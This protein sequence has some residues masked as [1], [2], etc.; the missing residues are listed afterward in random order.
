VE[1]QLR[2]AAGE[3]LPQ[4]QDQ[5]HITG[6]AIEARVYAEDPA[7][8][9][10]P[11]IGTLVHL[12][13]PVETADV[14]VDTGV[15]QGDAITPNYDPMIAKL[16]V[17]GKDR[18]AAVQRLAMTLAQYEV[19]GVQTNLGL[20]RAIAAHPAFAGEELDTGFIARHAEVL[21]ADAEPPD[22]ARSEATA[23]TILAAAALAAFADRRAAHA[24][25]AA[26]S[27]DPWSPWN[28]A[29]AW[30]MNG[31][32]YQ[33][34]VL[35]QG[36]ES[37][38]LRAHPAEDGTY[39][40]DLPCG[41]VHAE[42]AEDPEAGMTL[43]LDGV[44]HRLRVVRRD[45]ELVVILHGRNHL[46]HLIDPLAPPRREDVGSD[47]VTAPIPARVARILVEPGA[48]VRRGA[49]VVVLEA[50]KMEL[51]LFAP[52]DG[53]VASVRHAVDDMVEE[54]TEL[55]TFVTPTHE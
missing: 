14:R 15:R 9:F 5:L 21:L 32:G 18:A 23:R 30:R 25:E 35:R 19:V 45:R 39:R 6:H 1:W 7:R 31:D 49:P 33:D 27:A 3:P 43:R 4:R 54:G 16:I 20:L 13:Q 48:V 34:L 10:L 50:M 47:L 37:V 12:R 53:T 28:V 29:D 8:D 11:S 40:L 38:T 46:L 52:A 24:A 22:V 17:R 51:T 41:A 44:L 26:A 42:A 36:E 2:V 55:V